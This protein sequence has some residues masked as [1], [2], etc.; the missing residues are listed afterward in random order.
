MR[1]NSCG[2]CGCGSIFPCFLSPI[3]PP[4]S[5][6]EASSFDPKAV[7]VGQVLEVHHALVVAQV[8]VGHRPVPPPAV[9]SRRIRQRRRRR[10]RTA[11]APPK[12]SSS[13]SGS[14]GGGGLLAAGLDGAAEPLLA[15]RSGDAVEVEAADA[16]AAGPRAQPARPRHEV[17]HPRPPPCTDTA[18]SAAALPRTAADA[19][20]STPRGGS[21]SRHRRRRRRRR[22]PSSSPSPSPSPGVAPTCEDPRAESSRP[23]HGAARRRRLLR[24]L[25]PPL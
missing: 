1:R 3:A 22:C 14:G 25:P 15:W 19:A 16:A 8:H 7:H 20:A 4:G 10:R 24:R 18:L 9:A 21:Q 17:V 23:G 12:R 13:S 2:C 5:A 11:V 6:E